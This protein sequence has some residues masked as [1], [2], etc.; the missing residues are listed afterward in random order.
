MRQWRAQTLVSIGLGVIGALTIALAPLTASPVVSADAP[1]LNYAKGV[2]W[3]LDA[4][5]EVAAIEPTVRGILSR[6]HV[7]YQGVDAQQIE[8]FFPG[9]TYSYD[10]LAGRVPFYLY[11]RDTATDLPMVRYYYGATALR[12]TVEEF[13]R[14]QYPDGSVSATIGPDYKVDKATVVSDEET[15]AIVDATEAFDMLPDPGWL[16]Q[17]LQGQTLIE[18][19]NRAMGWVLGVRRDPETQ[20][21]KRAHTTD[22][23]DIKWESGPDPSHMRPGD[24]WTVSIYDQAIAYAALRGLARMNAA[25]GREQDR[26]RWDA[27]ASVIRAASNSVLWLGDPQ[28]G[29][30]RIHQHL[31]PNN[32]HHDAAE[33][34]IIAIGNAAAVYYGLAE[35]DKV[36]RILAALER[37]RVEA[38]APKPGLT[39]QPAYAGWFQ[40]QMDTQ[41]Y[42]NGALWDW[43]AGRQISAEFWSGYWRL[44]RDHLLMVARDWASHPGEVR[45][46]DSPWLKRSGADQA[47]A[48]A[49]A[50]VGQSVVE[51]LF[52]VQIAGKEVRLRPRLDELNGGIRVYE[53]ST[54]VYA[55]YE[56]QATERGESLQYGS[57]SPTALS[58]GLPVRWRGGTQ[59]RLDGKDWLPITYQP[60]GE[61]LVG[62]VIVPSGKHQ[63]EF[64]AVPAGRGKF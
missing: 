9:P 7:T 23:G 15:S 37:A 44:A 61:T 4:A 10:K 17:S 2:S 48:G 28:R 46:W 58:V 8:G 24:Q 33:D 49:A 1:D 31:E 51:G 36:Q 12:S 25:A 13:L 47:Y 19:L 41:T 62:I 45:E 60:S 55:A 6:V 11:I 38:G 50:V 32:V 40:V 63:I 52:G 56:Y 27:E 22:W 53:P 3:H 16:T 30:Y 18:R 64:R 20:L 5:P 39:L 34:D 42:Q 43:W 21:I 26:A 35:P 59:A 57:N 29:Y 54:D 14:E